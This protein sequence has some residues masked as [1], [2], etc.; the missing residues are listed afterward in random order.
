[1]INIYASRVH[2]IDVRVMDLKDSGKQTNR[3][4][5]CEVIAYPT[6]VRYYDVARIKKWI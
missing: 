5:P 2:E 4:Q 3:L 1:M 6:D